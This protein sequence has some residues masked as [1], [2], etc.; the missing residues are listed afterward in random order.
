MIWLVYRYPGG[1]AAGG[2][3]GRWG[4]GRRWRWRREHGRR[5]YHANVGDAYAVHAVAAVAGVGGQ[6]V[7]GRGDP[8]VRVDWQRVNRLVN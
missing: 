7:G 5:G 4:Q 8:L 3:G 6:V 1:A 2:M